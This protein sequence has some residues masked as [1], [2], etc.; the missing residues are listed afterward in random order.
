MQIFVQVGPVKS[1]QVAKYQ[2][3]FLKIIINLGCLFIN[4]LIN[5]Y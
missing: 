1:F 4:Y 2:L 5:H 3:D